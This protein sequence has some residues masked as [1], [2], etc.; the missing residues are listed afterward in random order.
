MTGLAVFS[1]YEEYR[2]TLTDELAKASES[3]VRIGY[4]LKVARDTAILAETQYADV[5]EFAQAEYGLDKTQVSRFI[6]INDRFS[7]GGSSDRLK[8]S[9]R[10]IG[11]AKLSM[12][13]LLPDSL[14][15]EITPAFSKAE[16]QALKEE[17]QAEEAVTPIERILEGVRP[18]Y[19]GL[20]FLQKA[21]Y[22]LLRA[23]TKLYRDAWGAMLAA[24]VSAGAAG[25]PEKTAKALQ[26]ILA[27]AGEA[28]HSVRIRGR[29]RIAVSVKGTDRD[30][31]LVDIRS[32]EKEACTWE[33]MISAVR[34]FTPTAAAGP[35]KAFEKAFGEPWPEEKAEV[36][37]VQQQE[38]KPEKRK[39]S[40]VT[41]AEPE[42]KNAR[43]QEE[44][45][46]NKGNVIKPSENV[47]KPDGNVTKPAE[48]ED[49]EIDFPAEPVPAPAETGTL[50]AAQ[51]GA[52][53]PEEVRE[54]PAAAQEECE[55]QT[56]F[57]DFP[58]ILPAP[59][60]EITEEIRAWIMMAYHNLHADLVRTA[61]K[62]GLP[63]GKFIAAAAVIIREEL[64][65]G[66]DDE[67]A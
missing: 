31:M 51:K 62:Y 41:K 5:I 67:S 53:E 7:E 46:Q 9:Y 23:D 45:A 37:P 2:K 15:E 34:M 11:Y 30:I 1:N 27:P 61:E 4:L 12:M 8:D 38:K 24:D 64:D 50:E 16:V 44:N 28:I 56:D 54:D 58:E 20:T 18:D 49:E 14:N 32:D 42:K 26:E 66:D 52:G 17:V 21:V 63:A 25:Q 3:F 6:R 10:G 29:G 43:N 19:E 47:I 36:A 39:E 60:I 22:E 57:E 55:G 33:D 59:E 65:K 13:L 35:E 48:T 40:K